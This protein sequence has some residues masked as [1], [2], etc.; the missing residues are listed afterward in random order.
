M[1]KLTKFLLIII[2]G[3]LSLTA[4]A[5]NANPYKNVESDEV[6]QKSVANMDA[7]AEAKGYLLKGSLNVGALNFSIGEQSVSFDK[8]TASFEAKVEAVL[9]DNKAVNQEKVSITA[10]FVAKKL[11][12]NADGFEA[13]V[14]DVSIN[15]KKLEV[16]FDFENVIQPQQPNQGFPEYYTYL[17]YNIEVKR[18]KATQ[19][20]KDKFKFLN[21]LPGADDISGIEVPDIYGIIN[22]VFTQGTLDDA[23]GENFGM[24]KDYLPEPKVKSEKDYVT[25]TYQF[26]DI[27]TKAAMFLADNHLEISSDQQDMI[28]K[29][30]ASKSTFSIHIADEYK[31]AGLSLYYEGK[32]SDVVKPI[33]SIGQVQA[34]FTKD[35]VVKASISYILLYSSPKISVKGSTYQVKTEQEIMTLFS[36]TYLNL[37]R[38]MFYDVIPPV[39]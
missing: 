5:C 25:F 22:S 15:V 23:F 7:L 32:F 19:V 39:F 30:A 18:G 1:T 36:G 8:L 21:S 11:V 34:V 29:L 26:A 2:I 37:L 38:G 27:A 14:G 6:L 10:N 17:D 35:P 4:T 9:N 20:F 24:I 33:T 28:D 31:F 16:V 3:L 13:N 12:A